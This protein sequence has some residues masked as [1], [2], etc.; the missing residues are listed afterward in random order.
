MGVKIVGG[1]SEFDN[2]G[3]LLSVSRQ[4]S[5]FQPT[6]PIKQTLFLFGPDFHSRPGRLPL[7]LEPMDSSIHLPLDANSVTLSSRLNRI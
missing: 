3:N 7:I 1:L 6:G 2:K 5:T 4:L